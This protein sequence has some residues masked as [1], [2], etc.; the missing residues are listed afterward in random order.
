ML[1]GIIPLIDDKNFWLTIG[2]GRYGTDA[3]FI[4]Q[5]GGRAHATDFSKNY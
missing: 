3:H 2:D 1:E 4:I 5:N